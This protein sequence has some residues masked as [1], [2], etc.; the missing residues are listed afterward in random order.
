MAWPTHI[1]AAGRYVFDKNSNLLIVKTY[2]RGWDCPGGQKEEGE[3]IEEGL[4]REIVNSHFYERDY[5][6]VTQQ[7]LWEHI[8]YEEAILSLLAIADFAESISWN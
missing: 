3:N 8:P 6:E 1:V 4:L 7:L 5:R 2:N